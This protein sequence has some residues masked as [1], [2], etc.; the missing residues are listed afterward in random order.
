MTAKFWRNFAD[1]STDE[2]GF[3]EPDATVWLNVDAYMCPWRYSLLHSLSTGKPMVLSFFDGIGA[4]RLLLDPLNATWTPEHAWEIE[5]LR[6]H[7]R[8]SP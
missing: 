6:G 3:P 1:R 7:C 8:A 5:E 2:Q 4:L